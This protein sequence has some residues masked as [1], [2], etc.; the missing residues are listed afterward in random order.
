MARQRGPW[1][2]HET[3]QVYQNPWIAVTEHDVTR[4]DGQPGVY[5][6]VNFANLAMAIL[7]VF[8]DGS[9]MLVGQHRFPQD[10]YSWEIPEGGGPLADDPLASARRELKEE[11]GLS[12]EN[13]REILRMDLSNSVTDEAAIGYLATGLTRGEAE[14]EGTEELETRQVPFRAALEDVS[15][16]VISD[17]LTV[18]ML[19]RAYYMA[20]EGE[21]DRALANAMLG[22]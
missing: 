20:Q 5:G 10:R 6:V 13:W 9:I 21:L 22:R 7:P 15:K 14:P 2:V 18:A 1:L 11:T 8:E 16:G 4:P 19:L 3:R 12:A 17:A